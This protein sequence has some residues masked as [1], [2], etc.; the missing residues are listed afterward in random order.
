MEEFVWSYEQSGSAETTEGQEWW[1]QLNE[2]AI[3]RVQENERKAKQAA[4]T[5]KK[6]R[7][8]NEKFATFLTYILQNINNEK[9]ISGIYHVFFKTKHPKTNTTFLR[10]NVNTIVITW[11][12]APFHQKQIEQAGLK[13]FFEKIYDYSTPISL[14]K[15]LIYL[16]DLSHAHHDN[17]PIN[18]WDF[19]NFLIEILIH[20]NL[21]HKT[22]N[23]HTYNKLLQ[24]LEQQLFR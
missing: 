4:Q 17:I 11:I 23:E 8:D 12:F 18:K 15:Y 1:P 19:L 3:Q 24:Q 10:K 20:Y 6:N 16:K 22:L 9:I 5:S 2:A 7:Q 13:D 21:T 14:D